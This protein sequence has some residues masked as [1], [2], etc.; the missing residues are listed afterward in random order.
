[1]INVNHAVCIF[2]D[3]WPGRLTMFLLAHRFCS[4]VIV[5]RLHGHL[6]WNHSCILSKFQAY[7]QW[8]SRQEVYYEL[9]VLDCGL[10]IQSVA[11]AVSLTQKAFLFQAVVPLM[12][13]SVDLRLYSL[14]VIDAQHD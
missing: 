1:M 7:H 5:S 11:M 10:L 2:C 4:T 9:W 14:V 13:A 8:H 3:N 6:P 12:G